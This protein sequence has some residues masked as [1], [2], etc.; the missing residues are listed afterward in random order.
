MVRCQA[1]LRET[2]A[3]ACSR[4]VATTTHGVT[5]ER[6]AVNSSRRPASNQTSRAAVASEPATVSSVR[7][8]YPPAVSRRSGVARALPPAEPERLMTPGCSA[9]R[10]LAVALVGLALLLS[11]LAGVGVAGRDPIPLLFPGRL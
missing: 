6:A 10:R 9:P 8:R 3:S 2:S 11:P 7:W 5:E 4:T 1:S